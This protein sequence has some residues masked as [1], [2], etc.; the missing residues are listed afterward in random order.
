MN[1][2]NN[3]F[4]TQQRVPLTKNYAEV[5]NETDYE[6]KS[7]IELESY[8]RNLSNHLNTYLTQTPFPGALFDKLMARFEGLTSLLEKRYAASGAS[9]R[10]GAKSRLEA[11]SL[12]LE[13]ASAPKESVSTPPAKRRRVETPAHVVSTRK[14]VDSLR[15]LKS[16][17][18][19]SKGEEE[20]E[21]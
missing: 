2:Y 9:D 19:S 5:F 8:A 20:E 10:T 3:P 7:T 13:S 18:T 21:D 6:G 14:D 1:S 12:R 4:E 11:A 16:S 15:A 17:Y